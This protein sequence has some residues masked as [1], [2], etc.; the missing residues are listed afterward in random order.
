MPVYV[1]VGLEGCKGFFG[2]FLALMPRP[3]AKLTHYI[4]STRYSSSRPADIPEL[5]RVDSP[6]N[7][8]T[9]LATLKTSFTGAIPRGFQEE[10]RHPAGKK[11]CICLD[12]QL[13]RDE[14]RSRFEVTNLW[15]FG[16]RTFQAPC[17]VNNS[18]DMYGISLSPT[19][20]K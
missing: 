15:S 10:T 5:I 14:R 8:S 20:Q 13:P 9:G 4:P 18:G 16:D 7:L 6:I 1:D 3:G 2:R 19:F 17:S 11:S 12:R